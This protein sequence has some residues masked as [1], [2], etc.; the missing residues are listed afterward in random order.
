[1][2]AITIV[3]KDD[4][5]IPLDDYTGRIIVNMSHE[6]IL[7]LFCFASGKDEEAREWEMKC[8]DA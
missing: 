5:L 7:W 1:M 6:E 8:E 2:S 4:K 3:V